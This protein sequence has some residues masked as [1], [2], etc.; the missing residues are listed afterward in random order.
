MPE[1][2]EQGVHVMPCPQ[3]LWHG[4]Q[5]PPSCGAP[6]ILVRPGAQRGQEGGV[7][8]AQVQAHRGQ[9]QAMVPLAGLAHC[10]RVHKGQDLLCVMQKQAVEGW[11]SFPARN[12]LESDGFVPK[13]GVPA[14]QV[15]KPSKEAIGTA[16]VL[17]ATGT[18]QVCGR[19][20]MCKHD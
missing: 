10:G 11:L 3:A 20:V 14:M 16:P 6:H 9:R 15:M 13:D 7:C 1:L 2:Q 8:G 17:S 19:E 18:L 5:R 4:S 12:L